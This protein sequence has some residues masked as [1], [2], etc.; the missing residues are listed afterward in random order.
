MLS[1]YFDLVSDFLVQNAVCIRQ[2]GYYSVVSVMYRD[3]DRMLSTH[4][5]QIWTQAR[6]I[7]FIINDKIGC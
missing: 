4:G 6:F 5:Y 1:F 3:M 2:I 7:F